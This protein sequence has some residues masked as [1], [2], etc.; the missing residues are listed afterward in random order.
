MLQCVLTEVSLCSVIPLCKKA[1][2]CLGLFGI[3]IHSV[4]RKVKQNK[5]AKQGQ[6][7]QLSLTTAGGGSALNGQ[8]PQRN[9]E[10]NISKLK[11]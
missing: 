9:L 4:E 7:G 1:V 2:A 10:L 11:Y 5:E 8:D 3:R 6:H